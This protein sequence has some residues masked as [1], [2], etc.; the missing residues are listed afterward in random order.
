MSRISYQGIDP[1]TGYQQ[2][3]FTQQQIYGCGPQ[4]IPV[5]DPKLV[6]AFQ[7]AQHFKHQSNFYQPMPC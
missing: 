5:L 2:L 4:S 7:L 6:A 1:N 3:Y